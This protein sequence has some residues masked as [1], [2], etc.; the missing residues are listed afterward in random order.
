MKCEVLSQASGD[1]IVSFVSNLEGSIVISL[2]QIDLNSFSLRKIGYVAAPYRL[3]TS[4]KTIQQREWM[5]HKRLH[6]L[7]AVHDRLTP[8]KLSVTG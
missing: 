5:M 4:V 2:H 3:F 7:I 6:K 1:D 8:L